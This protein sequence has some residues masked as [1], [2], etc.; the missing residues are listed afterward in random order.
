M[1]SR[2]GL[3]SNVARTRHPTHWAAQFAVAGELCKR[4]YDVGFTMGN[5]TPEAD[6][7]V[8][9]PSGEPFLVEVKGLKKGPKKS[10]NFWLIKEPH[11]RPSLYYVLTYVPINEP[12]R[13]FVLT[14]DEVIQE[15]NAWLAA[16]GKLTEKFR[17]PRMNWAA[18]G[19]YEDRWEKLPR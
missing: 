16:G 6:L 8:R 15:V 3:I 9:S 4:G 1:P 14:C 17:K 10:G 5:T 19:P 2:G 13:Y 18:A 11:P 7:F 12:N